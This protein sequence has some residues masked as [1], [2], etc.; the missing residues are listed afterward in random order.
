MVFYVQFTKCL[1][2]TFAIWRGEGPCIDGGLEQG[3]TI[4]FFIGDVCR[5]FAFSTFFSE[6]QISYYR[7]VIPQ[8]IPGTMSKS[9]VPHGFE[10]LTQSNGELIQYNRGKF[11]VIQLLV[12]KRL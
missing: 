9:V 8:L 10:R 5:N 7:G 11:K 4:P 3:G 2:M 12:R 6:K 1:V